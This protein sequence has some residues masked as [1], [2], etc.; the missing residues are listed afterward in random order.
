[1]PDIL[2]NDVIFFLQVLCLRQNGRTKAK[3]AKI[4]EEGESG[5][6]VATFDEARWEI[7]ICG[8]GAVKRQVL[9]TQDVL[10]GGEDSDERESDPA[11]DTPERR[12][13]MVKGLK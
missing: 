11:G 3:Y 6:Q 12:R 2:H 7:Y 5:P 1:M 9:Y 8:S 10:E 4:K 13:S